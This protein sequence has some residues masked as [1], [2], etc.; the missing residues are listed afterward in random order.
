M[1]KILSIVTLFVLMVVPVFS[2]T[3]LVPQDYSTIQGGI[4]VSSDGDTVLVSAGT[5]VENNIMLNGKE[6]VLLGESGP[7]NTIIDGQSNG[8]RIFEVTQ[9]ETF[10]TEIN[11]FTLT[12][13]QCNVG[14]AIR[15]LNDS[16][17]TV[18]N[19]II[20]NNTGYLCVGG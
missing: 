5:Y 12:N 17:L 6:I 19:C 14:A 11:G 15:I 7:N 10:E 16:Y 8:N 13:A 4:D 9:G 20:S 2:T 1:N 3:I 18:N